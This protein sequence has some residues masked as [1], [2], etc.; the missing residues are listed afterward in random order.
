VTVSGANRLGGNV[1][2]RGSSV[3][4]GNEM[5]AGACAGLPTGADRSRI[6]PPLTLICSFFAT[7]SAMGGILFLLRN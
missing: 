2:R 1:E 5:G 7:N 6:G 4:G 3:V